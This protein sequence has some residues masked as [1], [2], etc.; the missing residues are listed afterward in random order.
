ML[1]DSLHWG[2]VHLLGSSTRPL[3]LCLHSSWLQTWHTKSATLQCVYGP[4][5][6]ADFASMGFSLGCVVIFILSSR[7]WQCVDP[8][9]KSSKSMS[10]WHYHSDQENLFAGHIGPLEQ[11]FWTHVNVDRINEGKQEQQGQPRLKGDAAF[12]AKEKIDHLMHPIAQRMRWCTWDLEWHCS[13]LW[14]C[15]LPRLACWC[16]R[17]WDLGW[18]LF[19]SGCRAWSART[20]YLMVESVLMECWQV[21]QSWCTESCQRTLTGRTML[22]LPL[23]NTEVYNLGIMSSN[24]HTWFLSQRGQSTFLTHVQATWHAS[25]LWRD[26]HIYHLEHVGVIE[27]SN[28]TLVAWCKDKAGLL[29]SMWVWE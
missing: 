21:W 5:N 10:C 12:C 11:I 15:H 8:L 1:Q 20:N 17:G 7:T 24:S 3:S 19:P 23:S 22:L 4:S 16:Q 18:L 27:I 14:S 2:S 13:S 29:N 25:H 9:W 6:S 28:L 26:W